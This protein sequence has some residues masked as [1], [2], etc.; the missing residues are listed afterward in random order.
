MSAQ[1]TTA[2]D[3]AWFVFG[4]DMGAYPIGLFATE[5]EALRYAL[6]H[7]GEAKFWPY[8]TAW[9]DVEKS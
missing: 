8:G 1:V 5:V 6:A 7:Y 9:E 3:G 4:R 2:P